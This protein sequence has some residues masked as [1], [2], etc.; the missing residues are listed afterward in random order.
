MVTHTA[1]QRPL[2]EINRPV[3]WWTAPAEVVRSCVRHR[4]LIGSFIT[5]DLRVR[6]RN[7]I[8]GY[9]WSLL[10]P[11]LLSLVYFVLFTVVAHR[12]QPRY[13]LWVLVGALSYG[14]FT[15]VLTTAVTTLTGNASMIKQIY[16]PREIFALASAGSQM[17]IVLLSL[18]V[19]VPMMI[20]FGVRPN[21]YVLL[22]PAGLVLAA[23]LALGI[24]LG[25]ACLNAVH[26]DVEHF[27]KFFT[28]AG[29]YL[30]PVMW[31]VELIPKS[32]AHYLD[33]LMYN[34]LLVII[35][36]VRSGIECK[37]LDPRIGAGDIAYAVAVCVV[38]F[39]VGTTVF[40]RF[41]PEAVKHI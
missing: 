8:L 41:E 37:P 25:S 24:G 20:Y 17:V 2:V 3:A 40:K 10:E 12:P 34:P 27:F 23:L 22:L 29:F 14:Y 21:G 7:S 5:R 39:V 38:C 36:M 33:Y 1:P 26:G 31:T 11:L 6:Y 13:F 16:F 19:A 18:M 28:R 30:S 35:S 15:K 9:F 4:F 32:R